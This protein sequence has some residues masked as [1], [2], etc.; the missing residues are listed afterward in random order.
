M[1]HSYLTPEERETLGWADRERIEEERKA[2]WLASL[3]KGDCIAYCRLGD[4]EIHI[5]ARLTDTQFIA[6]S[7]ARFLRRNGR[8]LGTGSYH[9]IEPV[10]D[11]LRAKLT[12]RA[13]REKFKSLVRYRL[14]S[15][16]DAEIAVMLDALASL[17]EK[18][19]A[20]QG[21]GAQK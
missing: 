3:K 21:E 10:T 11:A 6:T 14:D 15:L 2:A 20:Q 9:T 7:G 17:R 19:A 1:S 18:Q 12:A 16:Q 13:N 4:I 5:I 8:K